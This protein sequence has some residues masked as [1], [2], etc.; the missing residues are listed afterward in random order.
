MKVRLYMLTFS[1][2]SN[3]V[4][5]TKTFMLSFS[6]SSLPLFVYS[7]MSLP[8]ICCLFCDIYWWSRLH[9]VMIK[10]HSCIAAHIKCT[11]STTTAIDIANTNS[12]LMKGLSV[13]D[14]GTGLNVTNVSTL[15]LLVWLS[16]TLALL[17]FRT[18]CLHIMKV[19]TVVMLSWQTVRGKIFIILV[20]LLSFKSKT[21][22]HLVDYQ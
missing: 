9:N 17:S 14:C 13:S 8:R 16:S 10:G 7:V 5:L 2:F 21:N 12:V 18:V 1:D 22:L 11:I 4:Y 19:M 3:I 20:A 15:S 6:Y